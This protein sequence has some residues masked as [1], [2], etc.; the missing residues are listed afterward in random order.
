MPEAIENIRKIR[1]D[2]I[3]K[4]R[5]L[6]IDPYPPRI[7][8]GKRVEISKIKGGGNNI[9]TAGRIMSWRE[10][11]KLIF[12]DLKDSTGK[13]QILFK[14]SDL[15][16]KSQQLIALLDIGDFIAVK[17]PLFKTKA[18]ELTIE[19]KEFQL[20][21]KSIR[22]IPQERIGLED[23]ETRYR[24]RYLDLLTNPEV[25]TRFKKRTIITRETRNYLDRLGY[26]EVETPTLQLLYGGTNA[27]PFKTHLKALNQ[28]YYLRIADELYLKR[29]VVGGYDKVYE[30]C[31]D[32]RNEGMSQTHNPEFT[33]IEFYEAY[34]DYNTIMKTT[35]GL[36]K[37]LAKKIYGKLEIK[38]GDK[39]LSLSGKWPK[40]TMHDSFKKY[41]GWDLSE[42][43]DADLDKE[44]KKTEMD[45]GALFDRGHKIFALFEHLVT[46]KLFD[47]VWITDYPREVSPLCRQ[48]PD[49]EDLVER[50]EGYI[51]GKEIADGWTEIVDPI[52]QRKRFEDEQKRMK[53]GDAE[54]HP[55]DK[56]FLK[57]IEYGMPPLGGIGIGIDRLTMFFTNTWSIKEV[58]LFPT[59][60]PESR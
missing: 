26:E 42:M 48:K 38:V 39:K 58:I 27:K 49:N 28:D 57:A 1:I 34:G 35:E 32:F 14:S 23:Q 29:C 55:L 2:K 25:R 36:F 43:S 16:A 4:I 21:T 50:F 52:E 54:A 10:H 20:L 40:I 41:L 59:M 22:P 45:S 18:G 15:K 56:D 30:L 47:P 9:V 13:I 17:G 53:R 60:R 37:H 8:I 5:K 31:K 46:P 24:Q 51:G 6:G 19:V 33:M 12:A 11:G 7:T 44:I 3:E